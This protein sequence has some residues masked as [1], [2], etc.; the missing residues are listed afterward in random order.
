MTPTEYGK[1]IKSLGFKTHAD[2]Y[3]FVGISRSAHFYHLK[4]KENG[5]REIP[6]TL[7]NIVEW[8]ENGDLRNPMSEG[9][10]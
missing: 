9:P 1:R 7:L 8:L 5:G 2:W 3:K 6:Q 10:F 4:G